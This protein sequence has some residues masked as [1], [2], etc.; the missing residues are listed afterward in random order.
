[1]KCKTNH[2]GYDGNLNACN[3]YLFHSSK[4]GL[5]PFQFSNPFQNIIHVPPY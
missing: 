4:G 2:Y 1:M 5:N 3:Y